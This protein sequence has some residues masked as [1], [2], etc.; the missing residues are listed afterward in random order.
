ME[1][2]YRHRLPPCPS[3]DVGCM[4]LWL[5]SMAQ[6][7]LHLDG[8][9]GFFGRLATF[10][11]KEPAAVKYRL[12]AVIK[13][14]SLFDDNTS[15]SD[16]ALQLA[17]DA[18]WEYVCRF[19]EFDIYRTYDPLAPELNTDPLLQAQS[20]KAV[21]KRM[22]NATL[23]G[24][25]WWI[26]HPLLRLL[27][28][29]HSAIHMGVL[30]TLWFWGILL[31]Q[32]ILALWR[33]WFLA[34]MRKDLRRGNPPHRPADLKRFGLRYRILHGL[35]IAAVLALVVIVLLRGSA[36]VLDYGEVRQPLAAFPG[37]SPFPTIADLTPETATYEAQYFGFDDEENTFA[38]WSALP[39]H[40]A[41][42]WEE[43]AKLL[44]ADGNAF[45][46]GLYI[47]YYEAKNEWIA[48]RLAKSLYFRDQSSWNV[49]EIEL[50]DLDLDYARATDRT[51]HTVIL[52]DGNRVL[53]GYFYNSARKVIPW[54]SW[55]ELTAQAIRQ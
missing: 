24:L 9:S 3:Y 23:T 29:V 41:I 1:P 45:T 32:L 37:D 16:E 27:G 30:L 54:D 40:Q 47:E 19:Q 38:L 21:E 5:E 48:R 33:I 4:E 50:P 26:L 13:T 11:E 52:Q 25:F 7:G 34:R 22:R 14:A 51:F 28:P 43:N 15:P 49:E 18:G 42:I 46:G 39:V 20:L 17:E 10:V 6:Q 12:E 53:R 31:G 55:L 35:H 2:N 8:A 36:G 44:F